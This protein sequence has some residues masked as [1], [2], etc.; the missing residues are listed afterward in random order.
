MRAFA[1]NYIRTLFN[2]NRMDLKGLLADQMGF[3]TPHDIAGAVFGLLLAAL[4]AFVV[5]LV[6]KANDA[7]SARE[8]ATLAAVVAMAIG[9]VRASVPLSIA[10]VAV[11]L[12]LRSGAGESSWRSLLM[13][14]AAIAIGVGCGSSA[15]IIVLALAVPLGLV[16]RWGTTSDKR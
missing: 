1:P 6:A 15:S 13:R 4:I 12:L 16:L 14:S 2:R 10:L 3:F 9:F 7:P 8:M 11:V 5:G